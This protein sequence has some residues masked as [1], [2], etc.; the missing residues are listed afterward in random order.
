M[1][2]SLTI[3]FPYFNFNLLINKHQYREILLS[4]SPVL[5]TFHLCV[6]FSPRFLLYCLW[7]FFNFFFKRSPHLPCFIINKKTLDILTGVWKLLFLSRKQDTG[8]KVR[9]HIK[10]SWAPAQVRH[11][12][13]SQF[14]LLFQ[15][16][17]VI[18]KIH[19]FLVC[20]FFITSQQRF[21]L[22][23]LLCIFMQCSEWKQEKITRK[24]NTPNTF[25]F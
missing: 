21:S 25:F 10:Y 7:F 22:F 9:R 12:Q 20:L 3:L 8:L 19:Y 13:K 14:F 1:S 17:P 15:S 16:I 23:P 24:K 5:Y 18:K 11:R 6:L 2:F 4:F